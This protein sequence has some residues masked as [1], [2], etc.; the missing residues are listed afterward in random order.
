M[1]SA[2]EIY[3]QSLLILLYR[4]LIIYLLHSSKQY[5]HGRL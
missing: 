5:E 1:H 2:N 4:R 3:V